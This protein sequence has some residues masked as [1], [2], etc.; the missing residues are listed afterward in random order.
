MND[1]VKLEDKYRL[2]SNLSNQLKEQPLKTAAESNFEVE[3]LQE[4]FDKA[5]GIKKEDEVVAPSRSAPRMTHQ[6]L[7]AM[8]RTST[9]MTAH[10]VKLVQKLSLAMIRVGF[11]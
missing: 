6:E 11:R 10:K 3:K 7:K 1:Q 8:K 2:L 5:V 4:L 9:R